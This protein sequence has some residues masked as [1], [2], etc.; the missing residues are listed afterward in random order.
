MDLNLADKV[1]IVTG[2]AK[3]IGKAIVLQIAKEGGIPVVLDNDSAAGES[4]INELDSLGYS[5]FF[6]IKTDLCDPSQCESAVKQTIKDCGSIHGLI[7]NAGVNDGVS[8]ENGNPD[9]FRASLRKN[10]N[11]YYDMA[12]FC[13]THLKK[14]SG[15]ILNMASK[16]AMTGQG[17]TS[18]YAAAKGGILA[19]TREWAV[20]LLKDNIRVNAIVPAEVMTPLY[21]NWLQTFDNPE[22]KEKEITDKIPLGKRMTTSEEIA[23][24]AL[25]LLSDKSSHITGQHIHVDGGYT[26]L[27]RL[28]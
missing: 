15:V 2:G 6:F 16:T 8:L 12:H 9:S 24:T 22:A 20:E 3:G 10:L 1:F 28:I 13:L 11:H 25:F 5:T 19:L 7:N 27:D 14:S 23:N 17:A 18:G 4:L 26:H 21:Q